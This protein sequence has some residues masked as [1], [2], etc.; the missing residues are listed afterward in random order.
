VSSGFQDTFIVKYD[1]NGQVQWGTKIGGTGDSIGLGITSNRNGVYVTGSFSGTAQVYNGS[2]SGSTT[3]PLLLVSSGD[4]DSFIVKYNTSGQVQWGTK[5][6]GTDIDD[7]IGIISNGYNVFV[8]GA[9][10]GTTNLYNAITSGS[11][12]TTPV[13]TYPFGDSITRGFLVKY[14]LNGNIA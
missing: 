1:T 3:S 14:D 4:S 9:T 13:V 8:C 5:I 12:P 6:G 11:G 2:S 10:T 7:G